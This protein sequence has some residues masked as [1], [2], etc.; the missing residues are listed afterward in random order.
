MSTKKVKDEQLSVTITGDIIVEVMRLNGILNAMADNLVSDLGLTSARC[1]V[2]GA[3]E[4]EEPLTVAQIA[5][6]MGLKR[7]SVQRI[8][9]ELQSEGLIISMDNPNHKK[10]KLLKLSSEGKRLLHEEVRPRWL[11]KV[12][13]AEKS[14]DKNNLKI[15]SET[16]TKMREF[17][18]LI[19]Q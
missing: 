11:K 14:N 15:T 9:N 6:N 17:F 19:E 1:K 2:L 4:N 13:H 5:R 3:I 18:E 7:Q 12:Y 16:L 8:S 10:A